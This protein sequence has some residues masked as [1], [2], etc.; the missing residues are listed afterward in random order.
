MKTT[1]IAI[2]MSHFLLGFWF[3]SSAQANVQDSL[4]LVDFYDSTNGSEWSYSVN[5]L[6]TEPLS[7]WGG[8]T[9]DNISGRV[10]RLKLPG[11]NLTGTIPSSFGNLSQ[12]SDAALNSNQ[13]TG[14]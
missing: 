7:T 5:W 8:V 14:K 3:K 1:L 10:V 13:I 11:F 12:L 6:T 9:V 4:A 2:L